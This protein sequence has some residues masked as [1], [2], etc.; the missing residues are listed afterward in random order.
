M[1]I[2]TRSGD[3][4]ETGLY[5][6]E[7]VRKDDARVEAYGTVDEA[8]AALGVAVVHIEDNT[9]RVLVTR[10]QNDLFIVGADLATRLTRE[11]RAHKSLVPRITA[12]HVSM[13]E[14]IIDQ[15]ES[16]LEPLR[17]FILPGGS[18]ASASLHLARG[19]VRRAERAA[20]TLLDAEPD[21]TN[22]QAIVYLNR[23]ADLLFVLARVANHRAG[24][25]D[26]AWVK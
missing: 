16:E 14:E 9:L 12:E 18:A 13:L 4:G 26:V 6:G 22:E 20:V 23:V 19:I 11:E 15:H 10:L 1:K 21:D 7:R 24:I 3:T 17:Q 8:N 25:A 5:G 2:Y